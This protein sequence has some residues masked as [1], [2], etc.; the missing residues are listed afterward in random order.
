MTRQQEFGDL[1]GRI[2]E[3]ATGVLRERCLPAIAAQ[4]AFAVADMRVGDAA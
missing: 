2:A 4:A 1:P 3:A